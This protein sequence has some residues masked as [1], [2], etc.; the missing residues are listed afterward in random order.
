ME[1]E[2]ASDSKQLTLAYNGGAIEERYSMNTEEPKNSPSVCSASIA[3]LLVEATRE[4]ADRCE[5]TLE[6]PYWDGALKH[7]GA[8]CLLCANKL[9]PNDVDG[10]WYGEE[11]HPP[12]CAKCQKNLD[13]TFTDYG[14][15]QELEAIEENGISSDHDAYC[16]HRVMNAGGNPLLT[17]S[18]GD[19]DY[20]PEWKPRILAIYERLVAERTE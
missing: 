15:E 12:T 11:D 6:P 2:K 3:Q 10:G 7:N 9:F 16:L 14:V 1:K 18:C 20:R 5:Q 8:Y 4:A 13:F 19:C 17:E